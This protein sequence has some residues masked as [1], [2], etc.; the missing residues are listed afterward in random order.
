MTCFTVMFLRIVRH[1]GVRSMPRFARHLSISP[2]CRVEDAA[3]LS[4]YIRAED[5]RVLSVVANQMRECIDKAVICRDYARSLPT[6]VQSLPGIPPYTLSTQRGLIADIATT[7]NGFIE[8]AE[9]LIEHFEDLQT[10][11]YPKID[12]AGDANYERRIGSMN[13]KDLADEVTNVEAELVGLERRMRNSNVTLSAIVDRLEA[14]SKALKGGKEVEDVMKS[15]SATNAAA[16]MSSD[17]RV[18][19][20]DHAGRAGG[21]AAARGATPQRVERATPVKQESLPK[22]TNIAELTAQLHQQLHSSRS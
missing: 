4:D 11:P 7:S 13:Q 8:R 2:V 5:R 19:D 1:N 14:S 20:Q 15:P 12:E 21:T 3:Q 16:A 9:H 18:A 10:E 6:V 22:R 17:T